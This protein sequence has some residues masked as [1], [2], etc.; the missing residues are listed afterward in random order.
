MTPTSGSNF[1]A[2]VRRPTLPFADQVG[3]RHA[4]VLVLLGHGNDEAQVAR[5]QF[6]HRVLVAGADPPREGDFL[7]A[8]EE[9]RLA[10]LEE[11]LVEEVAFG[12]PRADRARARLGGFFGVGG[13]LVG[14]QGDFF[15]VIDG[16]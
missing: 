6:L 4:A 14:L 7:L 13:G 3:E 15:G 2:A 9:G 1:R 8:G 11:I 10:D 5:D 12:A 16:A